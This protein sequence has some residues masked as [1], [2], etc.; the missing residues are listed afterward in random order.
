MNFGFLIEDAFLRVQNDDHTGAFPAAHRC[1]YPELITF[2][3]GP[4]VGRF[5]VELQNHPI[6]D[7]TPE[8]LAALKTRKA[9]EPHPFM[10]G[11]DRYVKFWSV[12]SECIHAE[13][14]CR[15]AE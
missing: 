14:A 9:G 6:F 12:V 15:G 4:G 10:T 7:M 8:R 13:I 2:V 11:T 1:V 3:N 5:C